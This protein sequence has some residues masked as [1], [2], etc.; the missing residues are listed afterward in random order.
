MLKELRIKNFALID[1]FSMEFEP[2]LNVL[3]GETGA[4]KSIII[5]ALNLALGCRADL[6]CIR[7]GQDT[8]T[9]EALFFLNGR[10]TLKSLASEFGI[11]IS[12]DE[13]IVKRT[14]SRSGKNKV[15]INGSMVTL[16]VLNDIGNGLADIHGQHQHQALFLIENHLRFLDS[17]G[18]LEDACEKVRK[19]E[20][21]YRDLKKEIEKKEESEREFARKKDQLQ[22][23]ISEIEKAELSVDE[24]EKL[25]L[26][27]KKMQN[28]EKLSAT[29]NKALNAIYDSDGSV[30]DIVKQVDTDLSLSSEI[31][32]ALAPF[33]ETS[34]SIMIQLEDLSS[35][36]RNY[37]KEIEFNQ[38]KLNELDDRLAEIKS[39]KRKYGSTIQ[40]ILDYLEKTRS[41]LMALESKKEVF[42]RVEEELGLVQKE[43]QNRASVLAKN[44]ED[45][46]RKFSRLIMKELMDMNMGKVEF[47]VQFDY[48]QDSTDCFIHNGKSVKLNSNGFGKSEFLFSS[49][50]GEKPKPLLKIASGG[51][52]SRV[53]LALKNILSAKE[54]VPTLVFDEV[55]TGIGGKVAEKVGEKLM[56]VSK[57]RQVLCI[58]HLPQI[59]G[60]AESHYSIEKSFL[61][62]RTKI[63]IS[64]LNKEERIEEIA[65]MSG[66]ATITETTR[67]HAEEMIKMTAR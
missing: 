45:A 40:D 41:D 63:S 22:Y 27:M 54:D 28:A 61:R 65:R 25:Q 4:G 56:K 33:K 20:S 6:E 29:V 32:P 39:L 14:V 16:S 17:F 57:G 51:E 5:N 49:N 44:R 53:M 58:T 24:E 43:L 19:L 47:C 26:E 8:A 31:D 42:E 60:I 15:F 59:A 48:E 1:E 10:E 2:G 34:N 64:R 3:T 36:L 50:P 37:A 11:E 13:L 12:E 52:V 23:E 9:V 55:D 46:S 18:G 67:R 66:G 62:G 35:G 38:E 7:E 21:R 30:I